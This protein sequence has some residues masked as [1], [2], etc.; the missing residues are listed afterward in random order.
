[1][2]QLPQQY[3]MSSSYRETPSYLFRHSVTPWF[4][5][6]QVPVV[7]DAVTNLPWMSW[8]VVGMS[9]LL[10]YPMVWMT[11]KMQQM[12]SFQ[13]LDMDQDY[14]AFEVRRLGIANANLCRWRWLQ[15]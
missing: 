10:A 3:R 4:S 9:Y 11:M 5:Q 14:V 6:P 15:R 12:L 2:L 1:M 13:G 7:S 8:R